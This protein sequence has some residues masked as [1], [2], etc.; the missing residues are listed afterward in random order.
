MKRGGTF[1]E[2]MITA[3]YHI[4]PSGGWTNL[5]SLNTD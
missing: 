4:N 2:I 1:E 3:T 5:V